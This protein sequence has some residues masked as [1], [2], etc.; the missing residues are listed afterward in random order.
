MFVA[1]QKQKKNYIKI[2]PTKRFSIMKNQKNH[3]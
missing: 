2:K 1:N 3:L